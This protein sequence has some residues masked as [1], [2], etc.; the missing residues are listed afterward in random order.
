ME[1]AL[2]GREWSDL[3]VALSLAAHVVFTGGFFLATT[4]VYKGRTPER[5]AEVEKLFENWN[6]PVVADSE[7]QQ[8]LDTKQRGML[9]KLISTAGL[10]ILAMALI[11]N[12]PT[13]RMLFILC[14]TMVLTVGILLVNASRAPQKELAN[15]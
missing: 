15:S 4:L 9:G 3:K 8:N 6:T 2:T 5:E 14:G 11:P 12:E 7:E 13:G 1:Q 10:G